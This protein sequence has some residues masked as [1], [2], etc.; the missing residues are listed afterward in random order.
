MQ[1]ASVPG[2]KPG[3]RKMLSAT[4]FTQAS[5]ARLH[6]PYPPTVAQHPKK[7]GMRTEVRLVSQT[8][9]HSVTLL[10]GTG[11]SREL[12]ESLPEPVRSI[13]PFC[14]TPS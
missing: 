14:G 13:S 6:L 2:S 8:S 12:V 10:P 5:Q 4:I 3:G 11:A 7:Q 9:R 1:G